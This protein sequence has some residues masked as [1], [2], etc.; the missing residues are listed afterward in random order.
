M[1]LTSLSKEQLIALLQ[2]QAQTQRRHPIEFAAWENDRKVE[3]WHADFNVTI[4][5]GVMETIEALTAALA[6]GK[7]EVKFFGNAYNGSGAENA[8]TLRGYSDLKVKEKQQQ[9]A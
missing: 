1:D 2:T 3:D 8:P 5:V 4:T 7:T 9:A 6:A